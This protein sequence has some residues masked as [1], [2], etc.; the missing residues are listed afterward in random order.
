MNSSDFQDWKRHPVTQIV[1][2][3]LEARIK[4]IQE[5]LGDSAG[6]N[7]RQDVLYVGAI[8]AYNDILRMDWEE[9][10]EGE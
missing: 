9:T 4:D 6:N 2:G 3:Q 5:I 7:V 1:F 8:Q 10:K